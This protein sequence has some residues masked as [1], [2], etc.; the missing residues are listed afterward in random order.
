MAVC[1]TA[2]KL[3]VETNVR[4]TPTISTRAL[5]RTTLARQMLLE[6]STMP[7]LDAVEHLVG[8]QAQVPASPYVGLWSRLV[9]FDPMELSASI[10]RREAVRI[11]VMRTTL[12]LVSARDALAIR[13]LVQPV[14]TRGILGSSHGKAAAGVDL[15]AL[16]ARG[17]ALMEERPRTLAELRVELATEFPGYDPGALGWAVHYLVPLVQIPPRG[18]WR[19]SSRPV[20]TTLE[21]WLGRPLDHTMSTED[22]IVR[23]L[24]A[25]G[26]ASSRDIATWSGLRGISSALDRLRPHLRV[27]TTENGVELFDVPDGP[28][29][30]PDTPAPPRFLPEYDNLLLSHHDRSRVIPDEYRVRVSRSLGKPAF[31]LDGFVAGCWS[32]RRDR[33]RATLTIEPYG[34]LGR[35]DRTA[36]T[37]EAERLLSVVAEDSTDRGVEFSVIG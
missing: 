13:A 24:R 36:L 35:A 29:A 10:E 9:G 33:R 15:D 18:L 31:L 30:A 14:L 12:H 7:P 6:R 8:M 4:A 17:R 34:R 25:F 2:G 27:L 26:P 28:I 20:C 19:G 37:D 23:Y 16:A 21:A 1:T 5:N 11:A 32:L 3:A 22:L